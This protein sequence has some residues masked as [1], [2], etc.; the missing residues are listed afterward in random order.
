MISSHLVDLLQC[1]EPSHPWSIARC[2][3]S[4]RPHKTTLYVLPPPLIG[5]QALERS[6]Y[7]SLQHKNKKEKSVFSFVILTCHQ[8]WMLFVIII[9]L[10]FCYLWIIY[11]I[12]KYKLLS[13]GNL[14]WTW[15]PEIFCVRRFLWT[16][17]L[18]TRVFLQA[19]MGPLPASNIV[20]LCQLWVCVQ[21]QSPF[22]KF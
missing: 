22:E 18:K 7:T 5:Q 19:G 15:L 17:K 20:I 6:E 2:H 21:T 13:V 12:L 9:F 3:C 1:Q 4:W 16:S 14:N 8:L 11:C 10:Y